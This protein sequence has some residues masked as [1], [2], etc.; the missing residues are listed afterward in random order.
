[1]ATIAERVPIFPDHWYSQRFCLLSQVE[2]ISPRFD[3]VI[4]F[5]VVNG[6][7]WSTRAQILNATG[8]GVLAVEH[9]LL[10]I[11]EAPGS[12]LRIHTPKTVFMQQIHFLTGGAHS[13]TTLTGLGQA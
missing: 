3:P 7:R 13:A 8:T 5:T 2:A 12:T 11:Q 4:D 6:C 10:S 9:I 1:M